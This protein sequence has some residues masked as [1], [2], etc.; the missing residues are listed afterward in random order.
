MQN[1]A[2]STKKILVRFWKFSNFYL[3]FEKFRCDCSLQE[4]TNTPSYTKP[5]QLT[6]NNTINP[7]WIKTYPVHKVWP[8]TPPRITPATSLTEAITMVASWDR[9]PHSAKKMR[10]K[11]LT[12]TLKIFKHCFPNLDDSGFCSAVESECGSTSGSGIAEK[13]KLA[14]FGKNQQHKMKIKEYSKNLPI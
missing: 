3:I 7:T 8:R 4:L 13:I 6:I 5:Q 10:P 9:S 14:E 1:M 11:A 12:K 2:L